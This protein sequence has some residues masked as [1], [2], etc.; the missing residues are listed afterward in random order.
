MEEGPEAEERR[1]WRVE[2]RR[3]QRRAVEERRAR[4]ILSITRSSCDNTSTF[5]F[6][7][8]ITPYS[9]MYVRECT[10]FFYITA[11]LQIDLDLCV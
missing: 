4:A 1:S 10:P 2:E 3:M 8:Q 9:F 6:F 7:Q 5:S 11:L